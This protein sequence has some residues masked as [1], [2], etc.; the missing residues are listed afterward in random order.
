MPIFCDMRLVSGDGRSFTSSPWHNLSMDMAASCPW[1]TA[2]M[3]FL[4]PNAASPPKNTW[5]RVD[6]MVALSTTGMPHRSNSIPA[7]RSI[8]GKAFSCPTATRT[9]SHSKCW[10]AS[11]VGTRS[12]RPLASKTAFTFSKVTPVSLPLSCVKALGTR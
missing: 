8:H 11:P 1:A 4:G 3:M 7:S 9:S 2:Q 10:S 6:C 12:R 5:G